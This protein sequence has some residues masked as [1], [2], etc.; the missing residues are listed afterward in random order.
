MG[1]QGT[2]NLSESYNLE[3][4]SLKFPSQPFDFLLVYDG[5]SLTS[6]NLIV[7]KQRFGSE[8]NRPAY[9]FCI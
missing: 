3:C 9:P 1:Y 8:I 5:A 4:I 6:V 7:T 2:P